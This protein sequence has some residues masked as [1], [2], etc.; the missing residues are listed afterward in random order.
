[1]QTYVL[2]VVSTTL[3]YICKRE[4]AKYNTVCSVSLS[5]QVQHCCVKYEHGGE[6]ELIRKEHPAEIHI[7]S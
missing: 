7:R 2:V 5:E 1:M 6:G 4:L 3:R